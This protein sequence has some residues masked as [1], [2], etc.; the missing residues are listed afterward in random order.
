MEG[1]CGEWEDLRE[2]HEISLKELGKANFKIITKILEETCK[3]WKGTWKKLG[4]TMLET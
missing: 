3:N 1:S 2:N 4:M